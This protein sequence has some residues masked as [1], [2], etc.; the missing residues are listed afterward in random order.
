M[1]GV[2]RGG[3]AHDDASGR[4]RSL[5]PGQAVTD[6]GSTYGRL[7]LALIWMAEVAREMIRTRTADDEAGE[8]R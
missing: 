5:D 8:P 3:E 4:I 2:R 1:A 7:M 6:T